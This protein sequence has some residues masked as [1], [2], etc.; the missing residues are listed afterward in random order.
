M[1][2][3]R[4]GLGVLVEPA[5]PGRIQRSVHFAGVRF[6]QGT[7]VIARRPANRPR[8][9]LFR[10][11]SVPSEVCDTLHIQ[12]RKKKKRNYT[13][14]RDPCARTRC[15]SPRDALVTR[16]D[17]LRKR[18]HAYTHMPP[19]AFGPRARATYSAHTPRARCRG[20]GL[21]R[22]DMPPLEYSVFFSSSRISA[23]VPV[24]R[25]S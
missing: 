13:L 17:G 4:R 21:A 18:T 16:T 8:A 24:A 10:Q 11:C 23:F 25:L 5:I 14:V 2:T 1:E 9:T 22:F 20:K 12:K 7:P 6:R 15:S 3:A 19:H